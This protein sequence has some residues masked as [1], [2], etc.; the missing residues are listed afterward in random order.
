MNSQIDEAWR[1]SILPALERYIAIPNQ[2]PAFDPQWQAHGHMERAVAAD[3]RLGA[4][5]SRS[6]GCTSRWCGSPGAR[7]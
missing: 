5:R 3:R 7:R 6:P 4:A 1:A 2:S